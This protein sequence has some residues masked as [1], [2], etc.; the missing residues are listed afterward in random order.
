M[1][2][3]TPGW[4]RTA[5]SNPGPTHPEPAVPNW[6]R[7]KREARID[8]GLILDPEAPVTPVQAAERLALRDLDYA[9]ARFP[10]DVR[11]DSQKALTAHPDVML[12]SP[13]FRGVE[14]DGPGSKVGGGVH[15][16]AHDARKALDFSL[17][18]FEPRQRG[19]I[20]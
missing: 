20:P 17:T 8:D 5:S 18:W 16:R 4:G 2:R 12:L 19:L 3:S 13:V 7:G 10:E 9:G 6:D 1:P 14:R 11:R 15:A